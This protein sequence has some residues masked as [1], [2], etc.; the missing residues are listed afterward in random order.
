MIT[1]VLFSTIIVM[2]NQKL[3][4][5]TKACYR[6]F[7]GTPNGK[8][9]ENSQTFTVYSSKLGK[10]KST[11]YHYR[12]YLGLFWKFYETYESQEYEIEE[13]E[14][15][16]RRRGKT[17]QTIVAQFGYRPWGWNPFPSTTERLKGFQRSDRISA[18]GWRVCPP[19]G[20]F[21]S[22]YD[23]CKIGALNRAF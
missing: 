20:N 9:N 23:L 10:L 2:L 22:N 19:G 12:H 16:P 13:R 17:V 21:S 18:P 11:R 7:S 14:D 3:F 5:Y 4:S 6:I 8:E 1:V 15:F